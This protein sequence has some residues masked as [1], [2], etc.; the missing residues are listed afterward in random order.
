MLAQFDFL[1]PRRINTS[2][3]FLLYY[4]ATNPNGLEERI[5]IFG[6]GKQLATLA[7]GDF[8]EELPRDVNEWYI[9]PLNNTVPGVVVVGDGKVRSNRLTGTVLVIDQGVAKTLSGAQSFGIARRPVAANFGIAGLLA[10]S[11][12]YAIKRLAF[13]SG[14][15]GSLLLVSG[16]AA[17][18]SNPTSLPMFNKLIQAAAPGAVR[19]NG[20]CA[21]QAPT[22]GELPGVQTISLFP[23]PLT[24]FTEYPLSTPI[25]VPAGY[26]FGAVGTAINTEVSVLIDGEEL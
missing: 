10:G 24:A 25:V 3:R 9:E 1:G 11:R 16:T 20:T 15:A 6:D 14:A 19:A 18:A 13:A 23:V 8:M 7:P 22:G 12:G 5:R 26:F 21:A 4:S 2:G 17:P